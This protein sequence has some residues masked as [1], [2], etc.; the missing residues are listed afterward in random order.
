MKLWVPNYCNRPLG[1]DPVVVDGKQVSKREGVVT[2]LR[3]E[4][5]PTND[6]VV[7]KGGDL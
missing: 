6:N 1:F 3:W 5:Q 4:S 2:L 7:P